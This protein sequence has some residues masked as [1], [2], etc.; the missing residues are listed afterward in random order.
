MPSNVQVTVSGICGS[1]KTTIATHI[2]RY[3]KTIGFD[4]TL[5]LTDKEMAPC[6]TDLHK[7]T[8]TLIDHGIDINVVEK[9]TLRSKP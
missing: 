8:T 4:V 7:R 1:G 6:P 2:Q 9:N 5:E 3:L